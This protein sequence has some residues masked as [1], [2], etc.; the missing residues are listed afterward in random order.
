VRPDVELPEPEKPRGYLRAA[1]EFDLAGDA[2]VQ[3]ALE[4]LHKRMASR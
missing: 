4:V 3:K 2:D 1:N